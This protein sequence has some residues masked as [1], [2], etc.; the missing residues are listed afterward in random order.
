MAR[1]KVERNISYDNERKKYYVNLE[2]GRDPETGKQIK[3]TK[4]FSKITEARAALRKHETERDQGRTVIPVQITVSQWLNDWLETVIKPNKADTTVYAYR[5]IMDHIISVLGDIPLQK[6]TPGQIQRYYAQQMSNGLSSNTVRKHHDLLNHALKVAVVQ[7]VLAVNP[8]VKVTPP[9]CIKK[10]IHFYSPEKLKLL[11]SLAEGDRIEILIKLAAYLGLRR[12]EILG[13]TWDN[14]DLDNRLI[15]IRQV[16]TAAG[17]MIVEK[18]PKTA[19]SARDLYIP[20]DVVTALL[21]ERERQEQYK[22]ALGSEYQD[23]GYVFCHENG[24]PFRPNYVSDLFSK[25]IRDHELPYIT[26]HGL[27]HSFA[28]MANSLGI[29]MYDIGKALGH[30]TPA[31]TSK[32]YTHL[33]EPTHEGTMKKIAE[34]LNSKAAGQ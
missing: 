34:A 13:L 30:S 9:K 12:E 23:L 31:T 26:L 5:H 33:L 25:F 11:M 7:D 8:V 24:R 15:H 20:D 3:K 17:S 16:R 29:P 28:T 18:D 14:V 22:E 27:R 21:R 1:T 6:L 19:T 10:E 2:F 4:T 32:V